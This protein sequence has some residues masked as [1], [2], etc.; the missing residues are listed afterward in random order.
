MLS[1]PARSTSKEFKRL[2]RMANVA[3]EIR[4]DVLYCVHD[5]RAH[6][7]IRAKHESGFFRGQCFFIIKVPPDRPH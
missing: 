6:K 4:H 7:I 2:S 3:A 1:A 5:D